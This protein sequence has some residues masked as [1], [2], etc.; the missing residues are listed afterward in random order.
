MPYEVE[1]LDPH[2][3]NALSSFALTLQLYEPLVTT[4]LDMQIEPCLARRWENPDPSTWIFHLEPAVVFHSGKRMQA[5]DVVYSFERIQ[6][7]PALE[8]GGYTIYIRSVKALDPTTVE[9]RTTRPLAVLLNKLRFV[10]IVPSGADSR[11]LE[12]HPD[13]TGPYRLADW[14]PQKYIRLRRNDSYWGKKPDL[15]EATFRLGRNPDAALSDLLT[16]EAEFAQINIKK[17]RLE[18]SLGGRFRLLSRSNIF[19]KYLGFDLSRDATPYASVRPNPFRNRLVREAIDVAVD[20][21]SLCASLESEAVPAAQLV[22]PFVFGFDPKIAPAV[23]DPNRARDLLRQA[24]L[25]EGFSATLHTRRLFAEAAELLARQ[26]SAVKISLKVDVLSDEEFY[27]AMDRRDSS[28]QLSRFGCITGDMSDILDNCL[29]SPDPSRHFGIHNYGSYSDP[30]VDRAI[31]ESAQTQALAARRDAL[32]QVARKVMDDLVWVPLYIDEDT[33]AVAP[34]LS[35][36]P[37]NDGMI[38]ASEIGAGK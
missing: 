32:Q 16:G 13:G 9:I 30:A 31:E 38:L 29:H 25:P 20:R 17:A 11:S 28:L 35:W 3:R 24:G 7:N 21:P 12:E 2:A 10:A 5:E 34:R 22:P 36:Q 1:Q 19:L 23:F 37:R 26:L 6:K 4:N 27:R 14:K 18:K 33:F 8:M 15:R